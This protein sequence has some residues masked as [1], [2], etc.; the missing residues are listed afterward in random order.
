MARPIFLAMFGNFLPGSLTTC[1]SLRV[2]GRPCPL[3]GLT[4]GILAWFSGD[5]SRADSCHPFALI[6][7]PAFVVQLLY[8]GILSF[9][10]IPSTIL[11]VL[12]RWDGR[13]HLAAAIVYLVY[14]VWFY[15]VM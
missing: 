10:H 2:L 11:S 5:W 7:A 3:C 12:R 4:T 8:R 9:V 15:A 13:I 1:A 14:A 6:A